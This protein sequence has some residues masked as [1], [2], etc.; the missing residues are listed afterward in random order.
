MTVSKYGHDKGGGE[1]DEK[2]IP[3][4]NPADYFMNTLVRFQEFGRELAEAG[5]K[6]EYAGEYVDIK[7][8][9]PG[10][11]M[12]VV[13]FLLQ[14]SDVVI[15]R[16]VLHNQVQEKQRPYIQSNIRTKGLKRRDREILGFG[17]QIAESLAAMRMN[18][19]HDYVTT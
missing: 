14:E 13:L 2:N 17:C 4:V 18:R 11:D 7:R 1:V 5:Q 9:S 12:E 8:Y 6:R 3:D 16:R 15:E 10:R 19:Q